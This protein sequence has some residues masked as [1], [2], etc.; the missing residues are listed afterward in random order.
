VFCHPECA[1]G[2]AAIVGQNIDAS[3]AL[4]INAISIV[5]RLLSFSKEI[6]KP[7]SLETGVS[8]L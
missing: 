4:L 6:M 1:N 3:H 5:A 8:R 7:I 2:G